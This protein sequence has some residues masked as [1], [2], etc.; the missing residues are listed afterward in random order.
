MFFSVSVY[1]Q[2]LLESELLQNL[3]ADLIVTDAN[4]KDGIFMARNKTT[5]KWGMF[6]FTYN[7]SKPLV[8]IPM[9]YDA[10]KFFVGN[11]KFTIVHN[12]G[13]LGVYLSFFDYG[14]EAKQSV[15]C[16]YDDY[17]KIIVPYNGKLKFPPITYSEEYLAVKKNGKWGWVNWFTGKEQSEFNYETIDDLPTPDYFQQWM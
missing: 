16:L 8:L 17:K 10:L 9:K 7:S 11:E 14:K 5:K 6:Q 1:S 2:A 3:N 12:N 4:N 13:K 15:A